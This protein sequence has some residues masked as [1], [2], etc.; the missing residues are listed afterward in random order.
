[1]VEAKFTLGSTFSKSSGSKSSCCNP[2]RSMA[3]PWMTFTRS[4]SKRLRTSPSH[5]LIWGLEG[6]FP[7]PRPEAPGPQPPLSVRL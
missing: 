7:A 1:M 6:P 3:S 2:H 4:L 5:L